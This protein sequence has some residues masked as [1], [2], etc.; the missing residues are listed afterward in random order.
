MMSDH[1]LCIVSLLVHGQ[2]CLQLFLDIVSGRFI[3]RYYRH[4]TLSIISMVYTR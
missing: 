1:D 3:H 4:V 2:W